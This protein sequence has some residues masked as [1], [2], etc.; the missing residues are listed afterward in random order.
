[1]QQTPLRGRKI[2]PFLKTSSGP[3]A[4]P[5]YPGGAADGHRWAARSCYHAPFRLNLCYDTAA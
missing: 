1:M 2:A 5:A 3:S 4:F